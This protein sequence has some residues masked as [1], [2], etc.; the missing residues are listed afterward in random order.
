MAGM[1]LL[2]RV[3]TVRRADG[4]TDDEGPAAAI[5]NQAS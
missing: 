5:S 3:S 4:M 1:D 2:P